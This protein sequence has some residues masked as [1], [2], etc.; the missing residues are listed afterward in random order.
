MAKHRAFNADRF[1]DKFEG[2]EDLLRAYTGLWKGSLRV[3]TASLDVPLFKDFIVNGDGDG[4]SMDQFLEGLYRAYDLSSERGH[5]DIIASCRDVDPD[6]DP[7]PGGKLPVE[8]LSLKVRTGN[9]DAFNLA[10][11]RAAL[12]QAERFS[13]FQG[14]AGLAIPDAR[15]VAGE[16]Q[17]T[18]SALFKNDKHSDRVL[19]RQYQEGVYTNFIVYHEKRTQALLTFQ[20]TKVQPKV[21]PTVLRPAQQDYISYNNETGQVEIEARFEKEQ[22]AL[23]KTFAR[24]CF[25]DPDLFEKPESADKFSLDVIT[26][27][28]FSLDVDGGDFAFLVELHFKLRQKFN[29]AWVVRSK[30]VLDTLQVNDF[31]KRLAGAPVQRAVIKIGFPDDRRGKRVEIGGTNKISFKRATH[32][33]DVFRYLSRWKLL[34]G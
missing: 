32:A 15:A 9:E 18:L 2:H 6:Y 23:R 21:S 12:H 28:D 13:I 27:E 17:E 26:C 4:A 34:R 22:T 29:P 11:D 1:V 10:Y 7:D 19:V 16:M 25:G 24:C 3:D 31:R 5:E 33:E 14:E 30:D 20:G 8:C